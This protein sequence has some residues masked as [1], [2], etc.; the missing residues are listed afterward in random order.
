MVSTSASAVP[1]ARVDRNERMSQGG[2][3]SS[4]LPPS[5]SSAAAAAAAAADRGGGGSSMLDSPNF[6][7]SPL[8]AQHATQRLLTGGTGPDVASNYF[9]MSPV[10]EEQS[11]HSTGTNSSSPS[12]KEGSLPREK[13]RERSA[14]GDR[15]GARAGGAGGAGGGAPPSRPHSAAEFSPRSSDITLTTAD[16][17]TAANAVQRDA[18]S[19]FVEQIDAGTPK[20]S[21]RAHT[22]H[23]SSNSSGT[24]SGS[25]SRHHPPHHSR[26]VNPILA[27][28][29]MASL[30]ISS[31][32]ST[33]MVAGSSTG[34]ASGEGR[35]SAYANGNSHGNNN[36]DDEDGEEAG[37]EA[38]AGDSSLSA[39][40][41]AAAAGDAVGRLMADMAN[42]LGMPSQ[43]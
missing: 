15:G 14:G 4:P 42:E 31:G 32:S 30:R 35:G 23:A 18:L 9:F 20:R 26:G 29:K 24:S 1:G 3:S 27:M 21:S 8:P 41:L 25:H 11:A 7:R 17:A 19:Y 22:A 33:D 10:H 43:R 6:S 12:S 38:G 36:H 28:G 40:E 34:N 16:A 5:K 13:R 39:L 2:S 37:E